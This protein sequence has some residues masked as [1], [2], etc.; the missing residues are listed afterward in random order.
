MK[1]IYRKRALL[2]SFATVG[3]N[4]IEGVIAIAFGIATKSSALLAFGL[5]SFIESLSGS[6]MIWRFGKDR[7]AEEEERVEQKAQK[8]VAYTFF[9]LG[10]YVLIDAS[11]QLLAR[12]QPEKSLFG[13]VIAVLSL[14]IMPAL[15][16]AKYRTGKRLGSKS[17]VADSKQTL[18]CIIMSVTLLIGVGLNYFFGIWWA[19]PVAGIAIALLLF[20]EGKEAL[21]N[22]DE[23]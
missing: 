23:E 11:M 16:L 12:E 21:E 18:A 9:I 22:E 1:E 6:V 14:I 10:A 2:L 7:S 20:H 4:L 3:Y 8:L 5:D 13:I 15:A 19:D 17:L